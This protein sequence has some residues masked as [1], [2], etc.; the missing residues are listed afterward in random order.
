[1][2]HRH[3]NQLHYHHVEG[4]DTQKVET[5]DSTKTFPLTGDSPLIFPYEQSAYAEAPAQIPLPAA[6]HESLFG[7]GLPS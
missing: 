3:Q 2:W 7:G 5:S 1:M 6:E 4:D